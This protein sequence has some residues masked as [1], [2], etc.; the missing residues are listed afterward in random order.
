MRTIKIIFISTIFLL[1]NYLL[2]EAAKAEQTSQVDV[3][4]YL[5]ENIVDVIF[6]EAEMYVKDAKTLG[7]KGLEQMVDTVMVSVRYPKVL[8]TKDAVKFLD[9]N[10][11]EKKRVDFLDTIFDKSWSRIK[12]SKN[13]KY[14][15]INNV[16]DYNPKG[17]TVKD[18][19]MIILNDEGKESWRMKHNLYSVIPSPRGDI[20]VGAPDPAFAGA[21]IFIFNEKGLIKKIPKDGLFWNVAFSNNGNFIALT[22]VTFDETKEGIEKYL[23][24]LIVIDDEGNEL[25]RKEKITRAISSNEVDITD[26][27]VISLTTGWPE[28]KVFLFNKHGE[29]I[30]QQ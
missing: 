25:W 27:D 11:N 4:H 24:H 30:N 22:I 14:I 23:G 12:I 29:S 20:I 2:T 13:K 15:A 7:A 28:R 18:A 8:V 9:L 26:N 17:E 21:P 5:D 6:G 3:G 10:G 1:T 19:E 16:Y